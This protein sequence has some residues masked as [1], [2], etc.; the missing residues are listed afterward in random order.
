MKI[1]IWHNLPSGGGKRALYDQ[2]TMLLKRGHHV[3]IWH[4][5]CADTNYLDMSGRVKEHSLPCKIYNFSSHNVVGKFKR[6]VGHYFNLNVLKKNAILS[7][8]EIN[9]A[10]FDVLLSH[11]CSFLGSPFI[12]RYTDIPS[13]LYLQEPN[14]LLYEANDKNPLA[15]PDLPLSMWQIP[16]YVSLKSEDHLKHAFYRLK[17]REEAKNASVFDSILVNSYYSRESVLRSYG[18]NSQVCY[19]GVDS[20]RFKNSTRVKK[21]NYVLTVGAMVREKNYSFI[22]NALSLI[23]KER[24]QFVI[25]SNVANEKYEKYIRALASEKQ[26]DLKIYLNISDAQLIELYS[27]AR[28]VAYAPRLEPFGYVPLEAN[29]CSV[30]VVAV[31]EGGVR[32]TVIDGVNGLLVDHNQQAMADAIEMLLKS[33]KKAEVMG[34]E[35]RKL[36]EQIWSLEKA[37][38]RLESKLGETVLR[39]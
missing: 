13:V 38:D 14:R 9:K 32:E 39:I 18:L 6:L 1:A 21:R 23:R 3:E 17:A 34:G 36:V 8:Q 29:S 37:T 31:A 7:A 5:S 25:V 4:P 2:V 35:G 15:L 16:K 33:P 24:P 11:P 26:V 28:L 12:G 20:E 10:H 19:L 30:P 27:G 22:I